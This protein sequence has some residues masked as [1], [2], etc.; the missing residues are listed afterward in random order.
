M[1]STFLS[2]AVRVLTGQNMSEAYIEYHLALAELTPAPEPSP[3]DTK[4]APGGGMSI[5]EALAIAQRL[6]DQLAGK[7]LNPASL[8]SYEAVEALATICKHLE[9]KLPA[10]K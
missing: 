4:P 6:K 3:T 7:G 5:K 2:E 8:P 10:R 9:R 1:N